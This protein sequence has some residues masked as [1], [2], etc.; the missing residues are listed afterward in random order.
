[1]PHKIV[2]NTLLSSLRKKD[3]CCICTITLLSALIID[4]VDHLISIIA[5]HSEIIDL[6]KGRIV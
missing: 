2:Y 4:T 3:D 5:D 6:I 1:M